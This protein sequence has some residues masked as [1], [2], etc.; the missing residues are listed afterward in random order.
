MRFAPPRF[1]L[2]KWYLDC[3]SPNGDVF[4]GYVAELRCGV[5]GVD[6]G[7]RIIRL[8][9]GTTDQRQSF[10][11]G[12]FSVG[13]HAVRWNNKA[14]KVDGCWTGGRAIDPTLVVDEPAGSIEWQC[15]AANSA[16][17]VMVD[18]RHITGAGYVERISM[19]I[20]PWKLPFKQLRWGRYISDDRSEHMI[21]IDMRGAT[22]RNWTWVNSRRVVSGSVEDGLVRADG[23]DLTWESSDPIRRE[24][25]ARTLLGHLQFVSRLLPR[26]VWLIQE[27]KQLSHC[28]LKTDG[29]QSRG[30]SINEV[31][32]WL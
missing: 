14:L 24:N 23:A 15:L 32:T 7:A 27:D 12:D 29:S 2:D 22:T 21:W 11:V 6:Y 28:V 26:R 30:S 9:G 31:V 4:I 10:S 20:P 13:D 16:V 8:D 5:I 19:T 18:G 3:V 25:V 1:R 17:D